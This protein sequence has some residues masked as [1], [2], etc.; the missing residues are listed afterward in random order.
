MSDS[1]KTIPLGVMLASIILIGIPCYDLFA[2]Y[3]AGLRFGTI[4]RPWVYFVDLNASSKYWIVVRMWWVLYP[5][6][7][8]LLLAGKNWFRWLISVATVV[9]LLDCTFN[10]FSFT[11]RGMPTNWGPTMWWA[12]AAVV[13]L[14]YLPSSILFFSSRRLANQSTDPE[15]APSK[16]RAV[17]EPRH[18]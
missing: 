15:A 8:V 6:A 10:R 1:S 4:M 11:M 17:R 5:C 7:A 12:H 3:H 16:S 18:R 14:L 2:M 9:S 13:V